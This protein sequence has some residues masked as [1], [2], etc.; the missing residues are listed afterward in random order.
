MARDTEIRELKEKLD[1]AD[2][3][4]RALEEER[5]QKVEEH[6]AKV[7]QVREADHSQ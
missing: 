1:Q 4:R 2:A 3:R 5:K 7:Q 6:L